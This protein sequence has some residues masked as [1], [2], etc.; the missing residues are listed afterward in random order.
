MEREAR[1]INETL[2]TFVPHSHTNVHMHVGQR[3]LIT[4]PQTSCSATDA[5]H[6]SEILCQPQAYPKPV[7]QQTHNTT[8]GSHSNSRLMEFPY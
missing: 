4:L 6:Q 3:S 1:L 5:Q 7:L 8:Q 2:S